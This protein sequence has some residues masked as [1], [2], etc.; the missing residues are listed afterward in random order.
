[1]DYVN[2]Y[3]FG[4]NIILCTASGGHNGK[5]GG[6]VHYNNAPFEPPW[7]DNS[8][9]HHDSSSR[10]FTTLHPNWHDAPTGFSGYAARIEGSQGACSVR[11]Y[12]KGGAG[13]HW[14]FDRE[15]AIGGIGSEDQDVTDAVP[16]EHF[17]DKTGWLHW[18]DGDTGIRHFGPIR[19]YPDSDPYTEDMPKRMCVV[20]DLPSGCG[21][22]AC[23]R[24]DGPIGALEP[25]GLNYFQ[26]R[27]Y[28]M[29]V[30]DPTSDDPRT[31]GAWP[32]TANTFGLYTC[33]FGDP[34][35]DL[36]AADDN[37]SVCGPET[38]FLFP[39]AP[40][41]EMTCIILEDGGV[42]PAGGPDDGGE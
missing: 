25:T 31:A 38:G 16:G 36:V 26:M 12:T 5:V 33:P 20:L 7:M 28:D 1:M 41:L 4:G 27:S 24:I 10:E 29:A 34:V 42:G 3:I 13:R 23:M 6:S 9:I 15:P 37:D 30:E 35:N 11:Y 32:P 8:N 18:A 17:L 19:V 14:A 2:P 21:L 39:Y 22:K 40:R